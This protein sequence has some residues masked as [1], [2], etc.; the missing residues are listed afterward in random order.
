[1]RTE[2]PFQPG[3]PSVPLSVIRVLHQRGRGLVASA[4]CAEEDPDRYKPKAVKASGLALAGFDS[5]AELKAKYEVDFK[6]RVLAD[7]DCF[8]CTVIRRA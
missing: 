8:N 6:N 4:V 1:M 5:A 7:I 3:R 2:L